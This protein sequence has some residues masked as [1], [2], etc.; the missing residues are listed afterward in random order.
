LIDNS[1]VLNRKKLYRLQASLSM[2]QLRVV[3]WRLQTCRM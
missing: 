3:C 2:L 1:L